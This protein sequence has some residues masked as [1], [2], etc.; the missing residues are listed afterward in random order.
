M[1]ERLVTL[2]ALLVAALAAVAWLFLSRLAGQRVRGDLRPKVYVWQR[3][4][5]AA[6]H[7]C[8]GLTFRRREI[9]VA[10]MKTN[11]LL[12][13]VLT[14]SLVVADS[15]LAQ[16]YGGSARP[17]GGAGYRG[18]SR[19]GTPATPVQ[20]AAGARYA[21]PAQPV[22]PLPDGVVRFSSLATNTAFYFHADANR[23]FLWIK[24]SPSTASNTV[25]QKVAT[26]PAAA[27]VMAEA[28][29]GE[30]PPAPAPA[31]AENAVEQRKAFERRYGAPRP[32][33]NAPP[34]AQ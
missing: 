28:V 20:P 3:A 21:Q 24:T 23:S 17:G 30:R 15:C 26:L 13:L 8:E 27:L 33:T 6:I 29:A 12:W 1:S 5:S 25:N 11:A 31:D 4:T 14:G 9:S 22:Q 10:L 19:Y 18:T 7:S 16:G 2:A 34:A 32:A